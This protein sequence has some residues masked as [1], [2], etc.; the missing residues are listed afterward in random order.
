MP[1]TFLCT[2]ICNAGNQYLNCRGDASPH[3]DL[4]SPHRDLAPPPPILALVDQ[5]KKALSARINP[6]NSGRI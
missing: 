5:T 2:E 4:A 6:T 1:N 3:R